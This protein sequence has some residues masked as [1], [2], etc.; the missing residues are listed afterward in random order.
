M[1]HHLVAAQVTLFCPADEI[2]S[3]KVNA[4]ATLFLPARISGVPGNYDMYV[5]ST[6]GS[7]SGTSTTSARSV[8]ALTCSTPGIAPRRPE[9]SVVM[10]R[11]KSSGARALRA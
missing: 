5:A 6:V 9:I 3:A 4:G 2:F 10:T 7:S 11:R 1:E 8:P